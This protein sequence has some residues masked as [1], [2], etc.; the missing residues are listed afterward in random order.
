MYYFPVQSLTPVFFDRHRGFAMGCIAAGSGVGGVVLAPVLRYLLN[1]LG[2]GWT[3]RILGIWNLVIS[4]PAACVLRQPPGFGSSSRNKY[5]K[6]NTNL[7][8]SRKLIFQVVTF[9]FSHDL[10]LTP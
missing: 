7:L 6:A 5:S 10:D 2:I 9:N 4:L 8:T 1:E 3:L